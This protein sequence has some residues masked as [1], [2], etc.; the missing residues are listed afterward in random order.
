[1]LDALQSGLCCFEV[2]DLHSQSDLNSSAVTASVSEK[3]QL[4]QAPHPTVLWLQL[5]TGNTSRV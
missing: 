2:D 4:P 5:F 1:M 3:L